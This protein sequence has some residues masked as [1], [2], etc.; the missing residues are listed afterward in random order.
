MFPGLQAKREGQ[1]SALLTAGAKW[2]QLMLD[3]ALHLTRVQGTLTNDDLR[4]YA[5]Q[6]DRLP[7]HGNC[8]GALWRRPG[9]VKVGHTISR[10]PSNR[11]HEIGVWRYEP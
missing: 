6:I 4:Q 11:G 9:W 3:R 1:E 5:I 8:W 10:W 2:T 7:P